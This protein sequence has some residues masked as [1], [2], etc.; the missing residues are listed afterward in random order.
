MTS[1]TRLFAAQG[2]RR[3][4]TKCREF[5]QCT[6]LSGGISEKWPVAVAVVWCGVVHIKGE[7][8]SADSRTRNLGC[9]CSIKKIQHIKQ[10]RAF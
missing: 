10:G 2:G 4:K 7:Q 9:Q 6:T 5:V 3:Q 1:Q 8:V